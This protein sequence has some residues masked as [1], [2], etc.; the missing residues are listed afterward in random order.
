MKV[1]NLYFS[2]QAGFLLSSG[3]VVLFWDNLS[4]HK[5]KPVHT[6]WESVSLLCSSKDGED[7]RRE[8]DRQM[9]RKRAHPRI[10][11]LHNKSEPRRRRRREHMQN[12]IERGKSEW[13]PA[14]QAGRKTH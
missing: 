4:P 8:K 5:N 1:L 6:E 12:K 9:W 13:I 11:G 14:Y 3:S 7:K 2:T 10:T